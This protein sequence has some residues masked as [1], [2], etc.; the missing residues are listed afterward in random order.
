[1]NNNMHNDY[2]A[3]CAAVRSSKGETLMMA[4]MVSFAP[5][6]LSVMMLV[7]PLL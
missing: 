2:A 3:S 6:M 5:V 7:S 4:A 1:M